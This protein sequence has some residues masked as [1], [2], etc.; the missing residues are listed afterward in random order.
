MKTLVD[1]MKEMGTIKNNH[2]KTK[3][4]VAVLRYTLLALKNKEDI[5]EN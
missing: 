3:N 5:M 4:T 1:E 2:K